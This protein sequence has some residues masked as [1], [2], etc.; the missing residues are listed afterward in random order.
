MALDLSPCRKKSGNLKGV[1]AFFLRRAFTSFTPQWSRV[2]LLEASFAAQFR[3]S[4]EV[5]LD[6]LIITRDHD[7]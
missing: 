5:V 6:C 2:R 4:V 1:A 7:E 3:F